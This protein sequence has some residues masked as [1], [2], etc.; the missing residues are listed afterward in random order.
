MAIFNSYVSHY[1]RVQGPGEDSCN[2]IARARARDSNSYAARDRTRPLRGW[3][4]MEFAECFFHE[5]LIVVGCM[6][7]YIYTHIHIHTLKHPIN[8]FKNVFAHS[9]H[10]FGLFVKSLGQQTLFP[11][12]S[13]R[14]VMPNWCLM[15]RATRRLRDR[16]R[17][18]WWWPWRFDGIYHIMITRVMTNSLLL[19]MA[20]KYGW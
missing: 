19:K 8:I 16:N 10:V 14:V 9:Q 7:V 12:A 3:T 13:G 11:L 4:Q 20:I 17:M 1:Q 6:Y 2:E 5:A 18:A 15:P